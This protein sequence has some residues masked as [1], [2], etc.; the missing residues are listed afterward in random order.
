MGASV[1]TYVGPTIKTS[2]QY[3]V[4]SVQNTCSNK[5]CI[6]NDMHTEAN[7]CSQ[8]GSETKEI[9]VYTMTDVDLCSILYE[10]GEDE[11]FFTKYEYIPQYLPNQGDFG[12]YLD[13][14]ND[15]SVSLMELNPKEELQ[16]FVAGETYKKLFNF[17]VDNNID[18]IVDY[19]VVTFWS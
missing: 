12:K 7:F 3:A 18:L 1:N 11:D 2:A 16:K 10:M 6:L 8:C 13:A 19:E 9:D 17:C 14:D 4:K 15:E 5:A